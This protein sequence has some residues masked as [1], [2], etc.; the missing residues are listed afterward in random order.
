MAPARP[1]PTIL[2]VIVAM[3]LVAV[4]LGGCW[5][6]ESSVLTGDGAESSLAV[7]TSESADAFV[8]PP[9]LSELGVFSDLVKLTPSEDVL[10]FDVKH[11]LFSDRT[12]KQRHL[13]VP[14]G[15]LVTRS[16]HG[17]PVFPVGTLLLKSFSYPSEHRRME[18]RVSRRTASNWIYAT[19][20]WRRD[21]ADAD[22]VGANGLDTHV[23]IPDSASTYAIP[24]RT[25]CIQ[26]H[27]V[28]GAPLGFSRW[29]LTDDT[30]AKLEGLMP[31]DQLPLARESVQGRTSV[32]AHALGHFVANCVFCHQP[33]TTSSAGNDLDLRPHQAIDSLVG[34]RSRRLSR[35]DATT[36]VVAGDP[37]ASLLY[38]LTARTYSSGHDRPIT[39]P[40]VG[41]RLIDDEGVLVLRNW[42]TELSTEARD[43]L[44]K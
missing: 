4:S 12:A 30:A 29:Q 21:L 43:G 9:T 20:M 13:R 41:S 32:E 36:R 11:P 19:Y 27:G 39:M 40:P 14:R 37:E 6:P 44:S 8:F 15:A 25:A 22:L 7:E 38:R 26:C 17:E 5:C 31:P 35:A 1:I 42:I 3:T 16:E 34:I 10:A 28:D 18:T 23:A 24:S 2:C 33:G